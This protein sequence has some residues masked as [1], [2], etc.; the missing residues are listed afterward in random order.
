[1]RG[2]A[3]WHHHL[4]HHQC[5]IFASAVWEHRDRLKHAIRAAA[6]RLLGRAAVEAPHRQ[7]LEGRE[8][9]EFLD[10]GFAAEIWHGCVSIEPDV[11]QF[12]FGHNI[13]V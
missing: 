8:A 2:G 3:V 13:L 5:A 9:S 11:F 12:V 10:L 1:M 6:F 7:L 4:A